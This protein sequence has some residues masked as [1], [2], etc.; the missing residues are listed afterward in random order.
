MRRRYHFSVSRPICTRMP[1][2][3]SS[4][5]D[6]QPAALS[7]RAW[8][9]ATL[10]FLNSSSFASGVPSPPLGCAVSPS[11]FAASGSVVKSCAVALRASVQARAPSS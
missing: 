8:H 9:S 1:H 5:K 11:P 2:R 10:C 3:A 4:T 7:R 6:S